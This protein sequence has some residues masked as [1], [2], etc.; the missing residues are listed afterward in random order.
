M[1]KNLLILIA[2]DNDDDGFLVQHALKKAG[3]PNPT[4]VCTDGVDTLDYLKGAG[5]YAEAGFRD[6]SRGGRLAGPRCRCA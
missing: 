6:R 1:D 2:E 5:V 4:H 3:L